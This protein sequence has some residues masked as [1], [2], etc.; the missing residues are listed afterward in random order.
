M[1]CH[2]S[3]MNFFNERPDNR[4]ADPRY[5]MRAVQTNYYTIAKPTQCGDLVLIIQGGTNVLHSAVFLA[6]DIAFT[7]NG[8]NVNQPWTLM[9]MK[10]LAA[11]YDKDD[12]A[13]V[14]FYRQ[15]A[16]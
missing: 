8:N 9:R 4:F 14:Y 6:D 13:D 5:T 1:D 16:R 7:K 10:D 3:A 2:W 15:R 11:T 12:G